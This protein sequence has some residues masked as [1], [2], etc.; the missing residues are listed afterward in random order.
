MSVIAP[1]D[2]P[3]SARNSSASSEMTSTSALPTPTTSRG[4][5]TGRKPY[6]SAVT[7]LPSVAEAAHPAYRLPRTVVPLRYELTIEPDLVTATF[8]GNEDVVIQ[9]AEVVREIVLNA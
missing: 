9:V 3:C 4:A 1:F 5:S 8:Q 6:R 7:T 2:N